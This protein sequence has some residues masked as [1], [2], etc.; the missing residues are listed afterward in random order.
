MSNIKERAMEVFQQHIAL[1]AT[2]GRL[3]RK[4]VREQLMAEFGISDASVST[5]YNNCKKAHAPIVGL[6]RA[7]VPAGVRKPG[8]I[9]EHEE[10]QDDNDCFTVIEIIEGNVARCYPFLMQGDASETFDAKIEFWN[11]SEW[12]MIQG[13]G[14]NSGEPYKLETGEKEIKRFTPEKV[15]TESEHKVPET[16]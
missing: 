13:L 15:S 14:P 8:K 3:F 7:P 1:A 10:L 12:V 11:K 9:K 6:G 16:V 5:Y 4:T 2:D